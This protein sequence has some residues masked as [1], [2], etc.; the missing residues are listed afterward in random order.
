M[1]SRT[2]KAISTPALAVME[3]YWECA[4]GIS[5]SGIIKYKEEICP[6]LW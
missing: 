1:F 2:G 3:M 6:E 4:I 5:R